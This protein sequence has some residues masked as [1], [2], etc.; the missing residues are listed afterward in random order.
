MNQGATIAEAEILLFLH[1]D[2]KLP[3]T[4]AQ[5]IP[6]T[7]AKPQI[8]AGAFELAIDSPKKSLR[9]VE[10]LVN[11]R[12]RFF[13]LPYGDQALFLKQKTFQAIGGFADLPIMEDFELVKGLNRYGKIRIISAKVITSSR[14]WDKLGVFKTTLINQ[15]IILGYYLGFSPIKLNNFYRGVKK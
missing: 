11:W 14:R 12:S 9:L 1:A 8:I 10:T 13:S 3:P 7:L 5:L 4:Y 6:E 2:T 15:L